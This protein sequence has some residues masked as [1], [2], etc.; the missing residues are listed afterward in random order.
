[1]LQSIGDMTQRLN[2][3]TTMQGGLDGQSLLIL[4]YCYWC[5]PRGSQERC[6]TGS[7]WN[8]LGPFPISTWVPWQHRS[9]LQGLTPRLLP[10]FPGGLSMPS[11]SQLALDNGRLNFLSLF[12][13]KQ[14]PR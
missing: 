8:G 5:L 6:F 9:P 3:T 1:M 4:F 11:C 13:G 2:N 7:R 14:G 10:T 12:G